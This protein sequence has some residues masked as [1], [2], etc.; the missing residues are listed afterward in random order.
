LETFAIVAPDRDSRECLA[1]LHELEDEDARCGVYGAF[2]GARRLLCDLP[3]DAWAVVTSNYA[4]RVAIRFERLGLPQ[5]PVVIDAEAVE[6]G[7][8]DPEG[9]LAAARRLGMTP[10]QCL[11]CEDGDAGVRAGLDAGM[12]VWAVNTGATSTAAHRRYPTLEHA[13]DD[14]RAWVCG[15]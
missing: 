3:A 13:V 2:A 8:P 5:P 7:K 9:Y 4:H 12:T 14:I 1:T 15:R 10:E 11:V 6:R